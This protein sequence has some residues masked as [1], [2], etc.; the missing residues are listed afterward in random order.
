MGL[1][2]GGV[3]ASA[4]GG[5]PALEV[6]GPAFGFAGLG[7]V[8]GFGSAWPQ[9]QMFG[10]AVLRA[11]GLPGRLALT[12]DDGPLADATPALAALL[13]RYDARATCFLLADRAK[14]APELV[15]RLAE[16][17]EI[18]LHGPA[19]DTGL[20]WASPAKGAAALRDAAACLEDL[21]G[22]RVRWFRPPFG[23]TS[24]RMHAALAATELRMVWCSVRTGDGGPASDA[25]VRQRA[26]GAGPGD[27]VLLHDG[28]RRTRALLP[29]VLTGLR[30][31]GLGFATVGELLDAQ[32]GSRL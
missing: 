13:D 30:A 21:C 28:P 20:V 11:P 2:A 16:R 14:A 25:L 24:P 4:L 18:A 5:P 6:L 8:A 7:A 23:V 15:K 32:R 29:E 19:H 9:L 22:Q 27:I 26:L 1:A 10:P 17:H 12:F 31:R 3:I